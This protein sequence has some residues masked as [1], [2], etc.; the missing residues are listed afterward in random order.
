LPLAAPVEPDE[1]QQA[2]HQGRDGKQHFRRDL[3]GSLDNASSN[4]SWQIKLPG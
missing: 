3:E 2:G 4:V 1:N